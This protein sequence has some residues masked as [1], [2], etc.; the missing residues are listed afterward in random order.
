[1]QLD[2]KYPLVRAYFY[3][4]VWAILET[5]WHEMQA[6]LEYFAA[7]NRYTAEEVQQIVGATRPAAR[8]VGQVAVLP[9]YGT[10]SKRA[11]LLGESSGGTSVDAFAKQ[12]RAYLSDPAVSAIVID[13]DSP[14][15][16]VEGIPEMASELYA[17][18]GVKPILAV[19]NTIAASAA[20]WLVSAAEEVYVTPSGQ[21]G[22]IGVFAAHD[23]LSK[24]MEAAG[25][26]TTLVSAGKYKTE[27]S[28]YEPLGDEA[29]A[30][31]QENVDAYYD[32]FTKA[33]AKG[34]GVPV[35]TVRGGYGEGRMA[36]AK[37][38][39]DLGMVDGVATL[40]QVIEIAQKR[41]R[42]GSAARAEL[43]YRQR[44]AAR[45]IAY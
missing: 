14:G 38:A 31:I 8:Q 37:R 16:S 19:A 17:S 25:V 32:L 33:V 41:V 23:D 20:Y 12:L 22:S 30:A 4:S 45:R 24:A 18:R 40:E 6:A 5:K 10:I 44:Q 26:K 9:L 27:G 15:G 34:R 43:E 35:D 36:V 7:G 1:M 28:P 29:R 21:V 3:G 13:A 39:A 2:P 11:G 42:A